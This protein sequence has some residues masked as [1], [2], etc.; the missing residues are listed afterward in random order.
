MA[1]AESRLWGWSDVDGTNCKWVD[2]DG[3]AVKH[4]NMLQAVIA[5]AAAAAKDLVEP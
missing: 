3:K 2:K 4:N 1:D 5:V